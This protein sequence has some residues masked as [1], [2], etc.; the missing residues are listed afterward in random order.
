MISQVITEFINLEKIKVLVIFQKS[1]G[2]ERE[3]KKQRE[4][5]QNIC[6]A[7]LSR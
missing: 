6:S 5:N 7:D 3:N 4:I 1:L 2:G